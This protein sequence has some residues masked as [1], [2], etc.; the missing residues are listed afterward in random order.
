MEILNFGQGTYILWKSLPYILPPIYKGS[1][2]RESG[3]RIDIRKS[4]TTRKHPHFGGIYISFV[5]IPD[6]FLQVLKTDYPGKSHLTEEDIERII[7]DNISLR[8]DILPMDPNLLPDQY[9]PTDGDGYMETFRYHNEGG[10]IWFYV[11]KRFK[12]LEVYKIEFEKQIVIKAEITFN[13][14]HR[15]IKK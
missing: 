10:T 13:G 2:S 8:D 5:E 3:M 9:N 4:V 7:L 1:Y 6:E 12:S 11:R 14:V 15:E